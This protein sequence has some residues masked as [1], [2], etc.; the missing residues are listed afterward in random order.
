MIAFA[1][2]QAQLQKSI[3]DL[4]SYI[5]WAGQIKSITYRSTDEQTVSIRLVCRSISV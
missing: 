1:L 2:L 4:S 5:N 3:I